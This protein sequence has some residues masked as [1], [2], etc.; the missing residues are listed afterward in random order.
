MVVVVVVIVVVVIVFC[1]CGC[2]GLIKSCNCW[3]VIGVQ[4]NGLVIVRRFGLLR[5]VGVGRWA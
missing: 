2:V 4:G 3:D 5:I 1:Y